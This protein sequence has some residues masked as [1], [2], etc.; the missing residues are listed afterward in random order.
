M[1]NAS[2]SLVKSIF[3]YFIL[4]WHCNGHLGCFHILSIVIS[5]AMNTK[6]SLPGSSVQG[7]FQARLLEWVATGIKTQVSHTAGTHFTIW[8]T[9]EAWWTLGCMWLFELR[10]SRGMLV[11]GL[12]CHMIVLFLVSWRTSMF[13]STVP[14]QIYIPTNSAR[15]FPFLYTLSIIYCL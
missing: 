6:R 3:R 14:V 15:G 9:R 8:A 7:I 11:V 13:S 1:Y 5:V 4:F 12:L 10:F 2:I